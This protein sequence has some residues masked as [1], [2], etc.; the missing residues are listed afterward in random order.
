MEDLNFHSQGSLQSE[1]GQS[2]NSNEA[3]TIQ[4]QGLD[5]ILLAFSKMAD[6]EASFS[7]MKE[8]ELSSLNIASYFQKL[9]WRHL[10]SIE[11]MAILF[12][13]WTFVFN[14]LKK[15]GGK[16]IC[17]ALDSLNRFMN[18]ILTMDH[19]NA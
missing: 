7:K 14:L 3:K 8:K 1:G 17:I 11:G 5:N 19:R 16:T 18:F 4:F 13:N 6:F 12:Q 10:V 9:N 15:D 2:E